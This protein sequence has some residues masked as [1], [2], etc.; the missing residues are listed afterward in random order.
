MDKRARLL[1]EVMDAV[2]AVWGADR[3]GVRLSPLNPF[4]GMSDSD[5]KGTF[6]RVVELLG[7]FPLAYLHLTEMGKE[8]PGAAGPYFDPLELRGVWQGV[9]MTNA[10]YDKEKANAVLAAGRADMVAFGVAYIAN[11]DLEARL[12]ADAP[13]NTPDPSTFYGGDA[14]GYTDYPFMA[15]S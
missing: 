3:V 8:A 6:T 1:L 2:C 9:L 12:R 11:P 5:P 14:R 15:D 7:R 4:N 10:S 13:L